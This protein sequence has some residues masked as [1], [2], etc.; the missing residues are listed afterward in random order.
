MKLSCS[1]NLRL[2]PSNICSTLVSTFLLRS[3]QPF[4]GRIV[5]QGKMLK[6]VYEVKGISDIY[7][8]SK[9]KTVIFG[10]FLLSTC[11]GL[12]SCAQRPILL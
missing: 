5:T 9:L 2:F 11:L 8:V 7:N 6:A 4:K 1:S 10:A 12:Q 3:K